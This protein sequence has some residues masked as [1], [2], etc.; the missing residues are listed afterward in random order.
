M[1][2]EKFDF[3]TGTQKYWNILIKPTAFVLVARNVAEYL[4]NVAHSYTVA[5]RN[6]LAEKWITHLGPAQPCSGRGGTA[7]SQRA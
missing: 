7:V 1:P 6:Q 4:L 2:I 3:F 5:S